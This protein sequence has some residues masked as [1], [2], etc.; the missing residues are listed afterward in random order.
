MLLNPNNP[1]FN[2]VE[3]QSETITAMIE[4]QQDKL[5]VLARHI[6]T[7]GLNP[8]ALILVQPYNNQWLVR[9]GNRRMTA[10]K[11]VNEPSLIPSNNSKLKKDFQQLN[12]IVDH[13][14]LQNIPCVILEDEKDINEWVRL[15]H[16]GQNDGAGT[17][18]WD[19][20]QTSRFRTFVEGKADMRLAFLDY[21]RILPTLPGDLKANLQNIKKTN[22]DR[23]MGDPDVRNFLGIEI[24]DGELRIIGTIN[25]FL[26]LVLYD[27][28]YDNISV[29]KIYYKENRKDYLES[30]KQRITQKTSDNETSEYQSNSTPP[31]N[32]TSGTN[33]G[34]ESDF[35]KSNSSSTN[36]SNATSSNGQAKKNPSYPINRKTLVPSIHKLSIG[37]PRILKIFNELK[38]ITIDDYPNAVS[39]L[40]RTFIE[41]SADYYLAKYKLSGNK[42]NTD[43]KLS[44]KINSIATYMEENNIMNNHQLRAIRQMSS[45]E[46]Q[47]QSIKTF[48]SYVHNKDVTPTNADLKSAWDDIWPFI[49]KI[50][51]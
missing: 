30:L 24:I 45:S 19:G 34:F 17:V 9:E 33:N 25:D 7:H 44:Y 15:K 3:Y 50:W 39:V 42:L 11:L 38:T 22:F 4:D 12:L 35:T 21:L 51:G 5:A 46:T 10:L 40:F 32:K 6:I 1:R 41:L 16:T 36:S 14:L 27:L 28:A 37:H 8:S 20:Q 2:P 26:M 31:D 18:S 47:N 23:L 13:D 48:H 49:E 29:G 43:S